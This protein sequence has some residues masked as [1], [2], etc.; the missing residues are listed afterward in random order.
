[1]FNYGD[2]RSLLS[3]G[4]HSLNSEDYKKLRDMEAEIIQEIS[5]GIITAE[6]GAALSQIHAR[7]KQ[8][9]YLANYES[10][11]NTHFKIRNCQQWNSHELNDMSRNVEKLLSAELFINNT[12]AW[13]KEFILRLLEDGFS[14]PYYFN[15]VLSSDRGLGEVTF[16]E[17]L[18]TELAVLLACLRVVEFEL[19]GDR[20][21]A[22]NW[23]MDQCA[24]CF[25]KARSEAESEWIRMIKKDMEQ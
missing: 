23:C 24:Y 2:L 25:P 18:K 8:I 6:H 22:L 12:E 5:S 1:M 15:D 13:L 20:E 11:L 21:W 19:E 17:S 10:I 4:V 14:L 3:V 9:E 7:R 16:N